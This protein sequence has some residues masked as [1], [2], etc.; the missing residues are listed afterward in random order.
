MALRRERTYAAAMKILA[1]C[2]DRVI[3]R[4]DDTSIAEVT[5]KGK[6]E[7]RQGELHGPPDDLDVVTLKG[8]LEDLQVFPCDRCRTNYG[9]R[10]APSGAEDTFQQFALL[11]G[12]YPWS[13][14]QPGWYC[15]GCSMPPR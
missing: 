11:H 10:G 14:N 12:A 2:Y 1:R 4:V 6:L 9:P 3:V 15:M 13:G 5:L 7:D 8:K